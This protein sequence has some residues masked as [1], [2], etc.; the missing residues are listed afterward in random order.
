MKS[1]PKI[2]L[3]IAIFAIS[4]NNE[5]TEVKSTTTT[6]EPPVVKKEVI[7]TTPTVVVPE[8]KNTTVVLDKKGVQVETKKIDVK[9]QP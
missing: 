6:T 9:V 2:L 8:K 1:I 5:P 4:C 3:P 7:V